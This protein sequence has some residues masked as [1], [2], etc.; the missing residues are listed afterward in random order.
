M[1]FPSVDVR[2]ASKVRLGAWKTQPTNST[3]WNGRRSDAF[4][5]H[6]DPLTNANAHGSEGVAAADAMQ[7]VDGGGREPRARGPQGMAERDC[8]TVRVHAGIVIGEAQVT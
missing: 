2:D 4:E 6:G 3:R 7:L 5:D 8:A 1:L